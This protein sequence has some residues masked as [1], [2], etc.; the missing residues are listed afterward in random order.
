MD[1]QKHLNYTNVFTAMMALE[2]EN[3]RY[4]NNVLLPAIIHGAKRKC[5]R[6]P[7]LVLEVEI[8][9][10][11]KAYFERKLPAMGGDSIGATL[12]S[13]AFGQIDW[14]DLARTYLKD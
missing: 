11:L 6:E 13:H 7:E 4:Y 9:D 8:A 12:L 5:E 2:I 3:S 10:T 14:M 1:T